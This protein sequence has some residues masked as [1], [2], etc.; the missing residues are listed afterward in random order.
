[1]NE[2]TEKLEHGLMVCKVTGTKLV[3]IE[4]EDAEKILVLLKKQEPKPVIVDTRKVLDGETDDGPIFIMDTFYRC[5]SCG[6]AFSRTNKNYAI[7]YCEDC[8]QAVKWE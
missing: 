3:H 8:G 2:Q 4:K 1:M 6:S 5:S 7:H